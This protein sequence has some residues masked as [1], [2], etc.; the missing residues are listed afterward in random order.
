MRAEPPP[1][2]RSPSLSLCRLAALATL[3]P[4][5]GGGGAA[6]PNPTADAAAPISDSATP[7]PDAANS[8]PD[9]RPADPDAA[10]ADLD[11]ETLRPS[12]DGA[13]PPPEPDAAAEGDAHVSALPDAYLPDALLPDAAPAPMCALDLPARLL[14]PRGGRV[15]LAFLPGEG[16]L[17][18]RD[19]GPGSGVERIVGLPVAAPGRVEAHL[20]APS[21]GVALSVRTAC[22][23]PESEVACTAP[24]FGAAR[25]LVD[26]DAP[27]TLW[28]VAEGGAFE[29]AERAVLTVAVWP[30]TSPAPVTQNCPAA[31]APVKVSLDDARLPIDTRGRADVFPSCLGEAFGGAP[32]QIVV[33]VVETPSRLVAET[34][35]TDQDTVL[36]L[37][38]A[39][40]PQS[41]AIACDD[42]GGAGTLSRLERPRLEPGTYFL[43]A[44]AV[45]G[46]EGLVAALDIRVTPLSTPAC[47]N[48]FDDDADGDVDAAD[49][50]CATPL[51]EDETDPPTPAD[52][53]DGADN[54]ANGQTDHPDDPACVFA[55]ANAEATGG[56]C[57]AGATVF[58]LDPGGAP[59]RVDFPPDATRLPVPC[60]AAGADHVFALPLVERSRVDLEVT[61]AAGRPPVAVAAFDTCAA[62]AGAFAC[63]SVYSVSALHVDD[64][65]GGT[66]YFAVRTPDGE[67]FAPYTVRARVESLIRACNDSVDNDADALTDLFDPGCVFDFDDDEANDPAAPPQCANGADD[68]ADG[69]A[70]YPADQDCRAAGGTTEQPSCATDVPLTRVTPPGGRYTLQT[71]GFDRYQATCGAPT[72]PEQAL[73]IRIDRPSNLRLTVENNDYDTVLFVRAA[74]DDADAELGLQRRHQRPRLRGPPGRPHRGHLLRLP[75]WLRRRHRPRGRRRGDHPAAVRPMTPLRTHSFMLRAALALALLAC[76]SGGGDQS[77]HDARPDDPPR[78]RPARR[79][80]TPRR[81]RRRRTQ[82]LLRAPRTPPRCHRMRPR[83]PTR[84]RRSRPMP[85]RSKTPLGPPTG[86]FLRTPCSPTPPHRCARTRRRRS[87]PRI[88][89]T[90]SRSRSTRT[91]WPRWRTTARTACRVTSSS[92]AYRCPTA[93]SGRRAASARCLRSPPNPGSA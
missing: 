15:N 80:P 7:T 32:E 3:L 87:S 93:A 14:P 57:G 31:D 77:A 92:M 69:S 89:S 56:L 70:D 21:G 75:R 41:P 25:L 17:D 28:F 79:R 40:D 22:D 51:D 52:C 47:A 50:G 24:D 19:C 20:E 74:C 55:G 61:D 73:A 29:P 8:E 11:A 78:T 44:E 12:P 65:P 91:I 81:P 18:T 33:L 38:A 34:S 48:D 86:S 49:P 63:E 6:D 88:D 2:R 83:R 1:T 66:L 43:S 16:L 37:F 35:N 53:A 84:V 36:G 62:D 13:P 10:V 39:C 85:P 26:V 45:L 30:P 72:G 71:E 54:D 90:S 46:G 82:R 59:I 58:P 76:D 60:A 4:A 68:D 67:A 27:Q 9:A 23:A 42:D 64:H 5:C